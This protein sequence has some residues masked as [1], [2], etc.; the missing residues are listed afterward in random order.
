M[1]SD[2][3]SEEI[4]VKPLIMHITEVSSGGVLPIIVN[5]CNG[6]VDNYRVIFAYGIRPDTPKNIEEY[7]D[8]KV[9][10][11]QIPSFTRELSLCKDI[12]AS[13]E[14]KRLVSLYKPKWIHFHS[15]KA[16][17]VGRIALRNYTCKKYY[18]PQG[19]SFLKMDDSIIKR[20][21]YR[22]VEMFLSHMNCT[23]IACGQGEYEEAQKL[24]KRSIC[25]NNGIDTKRIDN[26]I[27]E[28]NV[29][30]NNFSIY[31]AGRIGPQKNPQMFNEI[32][33]RFPQINFVAE[34]TTTSTSNSNG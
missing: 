25:L 9:T 24:N 3:L 11:I 19:Y 20:Q 31:T 23:T 33:T 1:G 15:T 12:K 4:N 34:C 16:G 6:L 13:R 29:V 32:A 7:F 18:T 26:I 14:I 30:E 2:N 27:K 22:F 10:L 8:K 21:I 5:L 28:E 17:F